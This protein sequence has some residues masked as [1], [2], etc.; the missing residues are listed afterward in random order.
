M[1]IFFLDQ[2]PIIAAQS[3][4]DVHLR[5]MILE[6]AQLLCSAHHLLN[7]SLDRSK[8]YK[9]THK[10][11]PMSIWVRTSYGNY[12]WLIEYSNE[13]INEFQF[14]FDKSHKTSSVIKYLSTDC[15]QMFSSK[16]Y[17]DPPFCMPEKYIGTDLIE[18]YRDYYSGEKM[19]DKNG[20]DISKYTRRTPPEFLSFLGLTF[21]NVM[22]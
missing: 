19:K 7:S 2:D 18:S 5:K 1:N 3:L 6:S 17:T 11:H 20:K 10:N 21:S 9:L 8:L 22:I 12:E 13:L 4:H 16:E 14:R 15:G